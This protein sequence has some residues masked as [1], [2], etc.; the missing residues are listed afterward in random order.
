M[1]TITSI[2][3]KAWYKTLNYQYMPFSLVE[4][5]Q[6]MAKM[7]KINETEAMEAQCLYFRQVLEMLV[8]C[9]ANSVVPAE[10]VKEKR[11]NEKIELV[12][13]HI[14]SFNGI[15]R[16]FHVVRAV[17]NGYIHGRNHN[18]KA[19][20]KTLF[21]IMTK[22]Q[23]WLSTYAQYLKFQ[24]E[25]NHKKS[26]Y[27]SVCNSAFERMLLWGITVVIIVGLGYFALVK[28]IK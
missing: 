24:A 2:D 13:E 23:K 19:D 28:L 20:K 15:K 26:L 27:D 12:S 10:T 4:K 3:L 1:K 11:L 14:T 25:K 22:I 17:T 9:L 8:T 21:F 5:K 16:E 6:I 18:P 7:R